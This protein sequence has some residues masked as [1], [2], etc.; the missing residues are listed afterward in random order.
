MHTLKM[1]STNSGDSELCLSSGY[2]LDVL[3]EKK[4]KIK[5]IIMIQRK[6]D[7]CDPLHFE[8]KSMKTYFASFS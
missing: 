3:K 8:I 2:T 4:K 1:S 5:K 6:G 7:I